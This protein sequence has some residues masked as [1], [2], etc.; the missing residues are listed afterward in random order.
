VS[1]LD[2]LFGRPKKVKPQQT[3][4]LFA[5]STAAVT[6][7]TRWGMKPAGAGA[8]VFRPQASS[9]FQETERELDDLLALAAKEQGSQVRRTTDEFGYEWI[10]VQDPEFEDLVATVHM[11]TLT[12]GDR[13]FRDQL[14]AAVFRFDGGSAGPVYWIYNYKRG[15]W[16]PF[17]PR[18]GHERDNTEEIRL[19]TVM[20]GEL[21]MEK[22]PEQWYAL[23]G[24]PI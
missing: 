3:E 22:S 2:A 18:G 23:W 8:V 15:A 14:L 19:G 24:V 10:I 7:E 1:F 4:K 12:L 21:P 9:Y 16:Y 20:D 5:I 6:L 11:V 13:G 17:M